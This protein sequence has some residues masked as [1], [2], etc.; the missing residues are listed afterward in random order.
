MLVFTLMI[1]YV[2]KP[3]SRSELSYSNEMYEKPQNIT[4]NC[5]HMQ[6]NRGSTNN[7]THALC[8]NEFHCDFCD[9]HVAMQFWYIEAENRD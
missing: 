1:T 4:T 2:S 6:T 8:S 9:H 5:V 3:V 7:Y